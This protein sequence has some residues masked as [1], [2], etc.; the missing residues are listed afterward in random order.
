MST[1]GSRSPPKS[2]LVSAARLN[3]LAK[4]HGNYS[5]DPSALSRINSAMHFYLNQL[6]REACNSSLMIDSTVPRA[7]KNVCR[8]I[9]GQDVLYATKNILKPQQ[10]FK[11]QLRAHKQRV[12]RVVRRLQKL[13]SVATGK[14][15]VA[16]WKVFARDAPS[17]CKMTENL[18]KTLKTLQCDDIDGK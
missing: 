16:Q 4:S 15:S 3:R 5:V 14:A 8:R 12:G 18:Q 17:I 6:V 7:P 1:T 10:R 13:S 9:H 11:A 2:P